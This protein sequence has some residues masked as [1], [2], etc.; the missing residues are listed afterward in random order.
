MKKHY[1]TLSRTFLILTMTCLSSLLGYAQGET[2]ITVVNAANLEVVVTIGDTER[3]LGQS[4]IAFSPDSHFAAYVDAANFAVGVYDLTAGADTGLVLTSQYGAATLAFGD[5]II[6]A[7]SRIGTVSRWA[8]PSGEALSEVSLDGAS[9]NADPVLSADGNRVATF[10]HEGS[11][12]VYDTATGDVVGTI[13]VADN[14]DYSSPAINVDGSLIAF[15]NEN[16]GIQVWNVADG[17]MLHQLE[18]AGG[19]DVAFSADSQIVAACSNE[20]TVEMWNLQT[21][22]A[23]PTIRGAFC[24]HAQFSPDGAL[25]ATTSRF[26]V[27][28]YDAATQTKL[29]TYPGGTFAFSPDGHYLATLQYDYTGMTIYAAPAGSAPVQAAE[30]TSAPTEPPSQDST[31]ATIE[32]TPAGNAATCV[33][34]ALNNAN[35]RGG[36]GTTFDRAGSVTG[37][38]ALNADGQAT[39]ADGFTWYRL[40]S[41]EW[42]R[43]D[44]VSEAAECASLAVVG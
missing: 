43:E 20:S 39:S 24:E 29:A 33:I 34:T 4:G 17:T 23:M 7:V 16:G 14:Y 41:G 26:E 38:S 30:P 36:P 13:P 28:L 40:T 21:G 3:M 35:L 8:F 5:E 10:D 37:G 32:E 25:L 22:A 44:L 31:D 12:L 11:A 18:S 19:Y 27:V 42:I 9:P 2:P 6:A 15:V 1:L